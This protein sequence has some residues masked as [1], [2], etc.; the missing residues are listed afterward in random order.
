MA[1]TA[2]AYGQ[3]PL[4]LWKK[5]IDWVNDDIR[6]RLHT[7]SYTPDQDTHDFVNDL[8]AEIADAGYTAGG[9]TLTS[10]TLTYDAPTNT[11]TLDCADPT[12]TTVSFTVRTATFADQ[13]PGTD[14]TRP[15]ICYQQDSANVVST[16]GNFV[17]QINAGGLLTMTAA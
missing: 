1:V 14:A 10:K 17:V 5:L 4:H 2:K 15:L 8:S 13:T 12:W 9:Q 16:N 3:L 7:S 6:C 11:T